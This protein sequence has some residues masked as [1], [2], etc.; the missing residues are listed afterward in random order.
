MSRRLVI[1]LYSCLVN[2]AGFFFMTV[3]NVVLFPYTIWICFYDVLDCKTS[4]MISCT[5]RFTQS[6]TTRLRKMCPRR[7]HHWDKGVICKSV[8]LWFI[9]DLR[10]PHVKLPLSKA[11]NLRLHQ[12]VTECVIE[13]IPWLGLMNTCKDLERL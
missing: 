6:C 7:M 9:H 10:S 2:T 8:G 5:K 4:R 12:S 13:Q 3:F 1:C 11:L